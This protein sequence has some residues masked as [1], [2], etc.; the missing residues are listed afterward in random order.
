MVCCADVRLPVRIAGAAT[1][2]VAEVFRKDRRF[3]DEDIF[4]I[5]ME[6]GDWT[7]RRSSIDFNTN[8]IRQ[9][10]P[11]IQLDPWVSFTGRA[12]ANLADR[13]R[14]CPSFRCQRRSR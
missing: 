13:A 4:M 1:V 14:D 2:T 9:V 5:R 6:G 10:K 3:G 11:S 12:A 8:V 7:R